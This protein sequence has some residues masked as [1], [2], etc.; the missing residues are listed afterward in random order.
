VAHSVFLH[1]LLELGLP[2]PV[3]VLAPVIREHLTRDIKLRHG[4][5]IDLEHVASRLAPEKVSSGDE[6]RVVVEIGDDVRSLPGEPEAEDVRLPHLVR[7]SPLEE[8]WFSGIALRFALGLVNQIRLFEGLAHRLVAAGKM[9]AAFEK[10]RDSFH[11]K[12]GVMPL[13]RNDLLF[14]RRGESLRRS[15][16]RSLRSLETLFAFV[17]VASQPPVKGALVDTALG[18]DGLDV[19]TLFQVKLN[20]PKLLLESISIRLLFNGPAPRGRPRWRGVL[21]RSTN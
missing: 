10:L 11:P 20:D 9:E 18:E 6:P 8:S 7:C 4:S 16:P 19:D 21:T 12:G 5:A 15:L 13:E 3:Y 2:P 17:L 1:L 14:D